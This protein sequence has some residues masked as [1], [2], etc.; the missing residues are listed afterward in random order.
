M[1]LRQMRREPVPV[2]LD[3]DHHLVGVVGQPVQGAVAQHR[4]GR[5]RESFLDGVARGDQHGLQTLTEWGKDAG[6]LVDYRP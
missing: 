3:L 2:A 4:N 5:V 1:S 6:G